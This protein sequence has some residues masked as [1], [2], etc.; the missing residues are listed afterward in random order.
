M[1]CLK[2][3][4]LPT[5]KKIQPEIFEIEAA[6]SPQQIVEVWNLDIKK[7][8]NVWFFFFSTRFIESVYFLAIHNT[9]LAN[10]FTI[11]AD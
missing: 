5:T 9:F 4:N 6:Y 1:A 3:P 2:I 8:V 11:C 10:K 7:S